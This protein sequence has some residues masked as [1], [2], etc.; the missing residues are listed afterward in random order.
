MARFGTLLLSALLAG[1]VAGP[2][3][4]DP[5]LTYLIRSYY[6]HHAAE[7]N[8]TCLAPEIRGITRVEVLEDTPTRLVLKIRYHYRDDTYGMDGFLTGRCQ[9]FATRTFVIDRRDG[10]RVVGMSGEVRDR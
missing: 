6:R 4:L 7:R 5:E 9:D 1:C 2:G 3:P 8:Y 10:Y